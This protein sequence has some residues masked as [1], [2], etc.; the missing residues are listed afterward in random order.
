MTPDRGTD[1][2][3]R[4]VPDRVYGDGEARGWRHD[5]ELR[6]RRG[7]GADHQVGRAGVADVQNGALPVA[8]ARRL[9]SD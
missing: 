7:D 6:I 9:I 8:A 1:L 2:A 3:V 5:G 4:E